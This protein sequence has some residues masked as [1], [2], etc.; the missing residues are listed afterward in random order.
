MLYLEPEFGERV[1]TI[2]P[3]YF[4]FEDASR[5]LE[6]ALRT[7]GA[8][9]RRRSSRARASRSRSPRSRCS[10]TRASTRSS[11]APPT[12][13]TASRRRSPTPAT[14][15]PR[16]GAARSSRSSTPTREA[17]RERLAEA[18]V[19]V[20]DLPGHP[21]LRASVGAWNDESDL[22]RLLA[23]LVNAVCVYCGSSFGVDGV[24]L[25]RDA[26]AR[27]DARRARHP[28]R[29]RRRVG[30]PDGRARRHHARGRRRGRRRDPAGARGPR[31]RAPAA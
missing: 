5:G 30:R 26:D 11:S 13:P 16:A 31:D 21:Y 8:P 25:E 10:R 18:G 20:R 4:S 3:G 28:G 17:A 14:P 29:L 24:Y 19:A 6:S 12:W 7:T 23:A 22:E 2:A 9:L 1:R 15:S 27:A